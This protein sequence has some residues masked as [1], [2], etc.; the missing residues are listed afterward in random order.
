MKT[1][2]QCIDR[3]IELEALASVCTEMDAY[4]YHQ[5]AVQWR[6]LARQAAFHEGFNGPALKH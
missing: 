3:A 4:E 1:S 5:I 6:L 2:E